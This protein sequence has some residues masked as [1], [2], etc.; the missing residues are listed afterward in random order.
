M[1]QWELSS[2]YLHRLPQ[3]SAESQSNSGRPTWSKGGRSRR[4]KTGANHRPH[5][6]RG[7]LRGLLKGEPEHSA[8]DSYDVQSDFHGSCDSSARTFGRACDFLLALLSDEASRHSRAAVCFVFHPVCY[9]W[10][11]ASRCTHGPL[12]EVVRH[13]QSRRVLFGFCGALH[14]GCACVALV[15]EA[16]AVY[17]PPGS[18]FY[19]CYLFWPDIGSRHSVAGHTFYEAAFVMRE[20]NHAPQRTGLRPVA[21]LDR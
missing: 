4:R 15:A 18:F 21:E 11:L 5:P 7:P 3:L 13:G 14:H 6:I 9:S 8:K 1:P 2:V 12:W 20:P 19:E 17:I 10:R 16:S